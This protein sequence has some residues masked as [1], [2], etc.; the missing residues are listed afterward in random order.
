MVHTSIVCFDDGSES[1][2]ELNGIVIDRINSDLTAGIDLTQANQL[3]ANRN[4]AFQ[5]IGKVGDFDIPGSV[6]QQM[7]QEHNPARAFQ[8]PK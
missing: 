1:Q 4:N 2:R 5:G 3:S 7:M 6:A 8:T